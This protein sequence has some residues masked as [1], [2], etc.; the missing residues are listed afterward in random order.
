MLLFLVIGWL[1]NRCGDTLFFLLVN[2]FLPT[3]DI[4][5]TCIRGYWNQMVQWRVFTIFFCHLL[6]LPKGKYVI[7][8]D[9]ISHT[10][11]MV[12]KGVVTKQATFIHYV[13]KSFKAMYTLLVKCLPYFTISKRYVIKPTCE[14]FSSFRYFFYEKTVKMHSAFL[15]SF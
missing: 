9:Q 8:G 3:S 7:H 1:Q 4:R 5:D 14:N 2:I 15:Y 12:A 10:Q 13:T 6:F 11:S